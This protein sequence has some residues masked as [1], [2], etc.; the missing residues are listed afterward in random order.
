MHFFWIWKHSLPATAARR[1]RL[2]AAQRSSGGLGGFG[3][4]CSGFVGIVAGFESAVAIKISKQNVSVDF[5][6]LPDETQPQKEASESVALI[7]RGF[8]CRGYSLEL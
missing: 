7:G 6:F 4:S 5:V 2:G 8:V 1:F 3:F